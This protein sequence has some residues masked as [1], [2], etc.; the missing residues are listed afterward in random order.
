[1]EDI[2]QRIGETVTESTPVVVANGPAVNASSSSVVRSSRKGVSEASPAESEMEMKMLRVR[3]LENVLRHVSSRGGM[4]AEKSENEVVFALTEKIIAKTDAW[5]HAAMRAVDLSHRMV[6]KKRGAAYNLRRAQAKIAKQKID[7]MIMER[8]AKRIAK[9]FNFA[10][11][12]GDTRK[13]VR[14]EDM[15]FYVMSRQSRFRGFF[16]RLVNNRWFERSVLTMILFN[17]VFFAMADYSQIDSGGNIIAGTSIRNAILIQTNTFF[18]L[19]FACE[20][21]SKIIAMGFT[22]KHG[23]YLSDWWNILDFLV[24]VSSVLIMIDDTLPSI[25]SLRLIRILRPL[26]SLTMLPGLRDIV[27][28][29]F[30]S[31]PELGGVFSLMGFIFL[32][33]AIAGM[34]M[35]G[36]PSSHARCRLTPYPVNFNFDATEFTLP[37]NWE[38]DTL[39][40]RCLNKPNFN[41]EEENPEYTKKSSPWATPQDCY[42]P[43][44]PSEDGYIRLCSLARDGG[45][46]NKCINNI[47]EIEEEDWKWCGSNFDG[48]GNRRFLNSNDHFPDE[49][50]RVYRNGHYPM[51]D[52]D[53]FIA[54]LNYG[55]TNFDNFGGACLTIFQSIT[56]EGWTTILYMATDAH[57]EKLAGLYFSFL[58]LLGCFFVLQLLLAVLEDNFQSAKEAVRLAN[59]E[60]KRIIEEADRLDREANMA[61]KVKAAETVAKS[62]GRNRASLLKPGILEDTAKSDKASLSITALFRRNSINSKSK[63][64]LAAHGTPPLS[65]KGTPPASPH[66]TPRGSR[67]AI[68]GV[69]P[70]LNTNSHHS[71]NHHLPQLPSNLHVESQ[72]SPRKK[73][74]EI[75]GTSFTPSLVESPE[76][77]KEKSSL[78]SNLKNKMSFFSPFTKAPTNNEEKSASKAEGIF[79]NSLAIFVHQQ[80][81]ENQYMTRLDHF[82]LSEFIGEDNADYLEEVFEACT[83]SLV[84]FFTKMKET[85][86]KAEQDDVDLTE[87]IGP[88]RLMQKIGSMCKNITCWS[89]FEAVSGTFILLNCITLMADHYPMTQSVESGLDLSNAGLTLIFFIE[90]IIN[91]LAYGPSFYWKDTL[92]FFDAFVVFASLIDLGLAPPKVWGSTG[93][94]LGEIASLSSIISILR[95]FRLFRIIKLAIRVKSLKVLFARVAQTVV[96]LATYMILLLVLILIYTV[97]GLQFF[98][99]MFRYDKFGVQIELVGSPEWVNAPDQPRYTFDDFSSSFASVFQIITTENWNDLMYNAWRSFGPTAVLYS[100]S[101]VMIGT[102]ILMNLFLGILLSNFTKVEAYEEGGVD[103]ELA[104]RAA[105]AQLAKLN[106]SR[107]GLKNSS[108]IGGTVRTSQVAPEPGLVNIVD[109]V[110]RAS[111][112]RHHHMVEALLSKNEKNEKSEEAEIDKTSVFEEKPSRFS[113]TLFGKNSKVA[114]LPDEEVGIVDPK[115]VLTN[116]DLKTIGADQFEHSSAKQDSIFPL[117]PART[118]G[119]FGPNN[120]IR[121]F[122]GHLIGHIYFESFI[123]FLILLSS[124]SLAID[125]PL[126]DPKSSF[127]YAM[128]YFEFVTT[129]FFSCEAMLKIVVTGLALNKGAYLRSGWN[130]LDFIIVIISVMSLFDDGGSLK[131]VKSIRS[132][133]ALRP[134]RVISRAPGLRTIVNAV[135]DSIPDVINVLAVVLVC[136]SI[137]AVV[138]VNF[139]KGDLRTCSGDHF[140]SVIMEEKNAMHL[141]QFPLP[142]TDM[143]PIQQ[144]YFGKD[145]SVAEFPLC[146]TDENCC[147]NIFAGT[148]APTG[149]QICHCWGG[150][151]RPVAYNTLDNYPSALMAFFSISTTENWVDLMYAAVDARGIDM[152][153]VRGS[154]YGYIYFF[155]FFIVLGNFFA[156]NLFV[157]V[158]IDNFEKTKFAL[159]GD[160]VF[161]TPEQQEWTRAQQQARSIRPLLHPVAPDGDVGKFCFKLSQRH[162]FEW[163]VI[164]TIFLNTVVLAGDYFGI[165]D[166]ATALFATLNIVFAAIFTVEMCIKLAG[167]RRIYFQSVWNIFD[168][169]VTIGSDLGILYFYVTGDAG[170]MA[171]MLIRI[172]RVLR[173]IRLMEGLDTA[174]R[175]VDTLILTLPGIINISV[176]LLLIIF[177]YAVLGMQLFAK[178]EYNANY[179]VHANFRTFQ[180]SLLTLVRFATGEGWGNFMHDVSLQTP[181][182]VVDPDYDATMCGFNEKHGCI[183]LN[184]CGNTTIFPFL[185]SYT[186]LVT[187]VLFNLFVG[188]IIE[189]FSAANDVTKAL[190][191]EDYNNFCAHWAPFDPHA[192]CFISIENFEEFVATLFSPL[193]LKDKHPTHN[194]T[195]DFLSTL[196]LNVYRINGKINYVHFKECLVALITAAFRELK[197]DCIPLIDKYKELEGDVTF[198]MTKDSGFQKV[199]PFTASGEI[200][201]DAVFTLKEHYAVLKCENTFLA[202]KHRQKL[203]DI[204]Q[205]ASERAK[206]ANEN[207]KLAQESKSILA[208]VTAARARARQE[209]AEMLSSTQA[210]LERVELE[211]QDAIVKATEYSK[212]HAEAIAQVEANAKAYAEAAAK[213]ET[214]ESHEEAHKKTTEVLNQ[215]KAELENAEKARQTAE[216]ES[217]AQAQ[218]LSDAIVLAQKNEKLALGQVAKAIERAD[219]ERQQAVADALKASHDELEHKEK[220]R[221]QA[222]SEAAAKARDHASAEAL[223]KSHADVLVRMQE[224]TKMLMAALRKAQ[225]DA[226]E[227]EIAH[228]ASL[229]NARNSV[230]TRSGTESTEAVNNVDKKLV[231]KILRPKT[232][233]LSLAAFNE[234]SPDDDIIEARLKRRLS[235]HITN[236]T[237]GVKERP[238]DISL[239]EILEAKSDE[240][241]IQKRLTQR[242][243]VLLS[244]F[245]KGAPEDDQVNDENIIIQRR[246][247]RRLSALDA[248]LQGKKR[249][250]ANVRT[251]SKEKSIEDSSPFRSISPEHEVDRSSP[252]HEIDKSE[253]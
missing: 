212:S 15:S 73:E 20:M 196:D 168:F 25:S 6:L 41:L 179:S 37:Y 51:N 243:S 240:A 224:E 170:A 31:L 95:C 12:Q 105:A 239:P 40:Y 190:K 34:E 67:K 146:A 219:Q 123:Q 74:E 22:G 102:F 14:Y 191:N 175:L 147:P 128:Y 16:V 145:S 234:I 115:S 52:K 236:S 36:G 46:L 152:Q 68:I 49:N 5:A 121:V 23:A 27:K 7:L 245:K 155:I 247:T 135:F 3:N 225:S 59:E 111:K 130:A 235:V 62:F 184:G 78:A 69:V 18:T 96:D 82:T 101:L 92:S 45:G 221:Q 159:Q 64:H 185:L 47:P 76:A 167:L 63:L 248:T 222:V 48:S 218:S 39:N 134:L 214:A 131:A 8:N 209:N 195:I 56:Q 198:S 211:R 28:S 54:E 194:E 216:A 9:D 162:E 244:A 226:H 183:P 187:M 173:V 153:P 61:R 44:A 107:Q 163:F 21:T 116:D 42:W 223:A 114:P 81:T 143:N 227:R 79:G 112:V 180:R 71:V 125:S 60:E 94:D 144:S 132:L 93:V 30:A 90:M 141:M 154:N 251:E 157:G 233:P 231:P 252:V 19:F 137:F 32:V 86:S 104:D 118:L 197:G 241:V 97:A 10:V 127:R 26:R 151:W 99:N 237:E 87:P 80:D 192:T 249:C 77:K 232:P 2:P 75:R 202:Y 250:L 113:F 91:I 246:L 1:M 89:Y 171:I 176:L 120:S 109:K 201:N 139:L 4:E 204:V 83:G 210:N 66:S 38:T 11:G 174:K 238:K 242:L 148:V 182:C 142:W 98:A 228:E 138:G 43:L 207:I 166:E 188:V 88:P 203:L 217:V 230:D 55:Y 156:L 186:L 122:C 119:I 57:G 70:V 172:F 84:D 100:V 165:S 72:I 129:F 58:I 17:S 24:V 110:H 65:P 220:E 50:P 29:I 108:L 206:I 85:Y 169:F 117:N 149:K 193:G 189:G 35:F 177:I 124:L 161:M 133:R 205:K 140:R 136:F 158:M 229:E 199:R 103:D 33:F 160:L 253:D 213:A 53:L 106:Q 13:L 150:E 215:T 126:D 208:A 164:G 178:T 200:N 181:G